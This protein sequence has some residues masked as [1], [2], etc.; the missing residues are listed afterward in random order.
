MKSENTQC[1]SS[2]LKPALRPTT[3]TE[4]AWT[5]CIRRDTGCQLYL[6][7]LDIGQ[8]CTV[9]DDQTKTEVISRNPFT[10]T[11]D[12]DP[13]RQH[14]GYQPYSLRGVSA[15]RAKT[16]RPKRDSGYQPY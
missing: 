6:P 13:L 7:E 15:E 1:G 14:T 9:E 16:P 3:G 12:I 8:L 11:G 10:D 2:R 4:T 5:D